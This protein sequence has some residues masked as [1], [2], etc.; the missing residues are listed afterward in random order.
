MKPSVSS[1]GCPLANG[2]IAVD[3]LEIL[4][5]LFYGDGFDFAK[6]GFRNEQ[7]TANLINC[8]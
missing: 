4:T 8:D 5:V 7:V 6:D 1:L 3:N 2:V